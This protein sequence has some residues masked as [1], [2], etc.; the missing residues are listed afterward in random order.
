MDGCNGLGRLIYTIPDKKG[1]RVGRVAPPAPFRLARQSKNSTL[2]RRMSITRQRSGCRNRR[3]H[4]QPSHAVREWDSN[5]TRK[6][7]TRSASHSC[8]AVSPTRW[9]APGISPLRELATPGRQKPFQRSTISPTS[10]ESGTCSS[11]PE[12]RIRTGCRNLPQKVDSFSS[13]RS[14][15]K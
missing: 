7:P 10:I 11:A 14:D 13:G 15:E 6:R 5:P 8:P 4:R 3:P 2:G 1:T 9:P 12:G